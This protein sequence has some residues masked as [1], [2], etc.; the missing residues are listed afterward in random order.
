MEDKTG[1]QNLVS[2][3]PNRFLKGGMSYCVN[4]E[5]WGKRQTFILMTFNLLF[6]ADNL[7]LLCKLKR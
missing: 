5:N 1:L 7:Q 4:K 3:V 6:S 2:C